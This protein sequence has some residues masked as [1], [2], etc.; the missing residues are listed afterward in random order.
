MSKK[1]P[2]T[3]TLHVDE[4]RRRLDPKQW[5]SD[6]VSVYLVGRC[7]LTPFVASSIEIR[8]SDIEE[9]IHP[10]HDQNGF[11]KWMKTHPQALKNIPKRKYNEIQDALSEL[12]DP[13]MQKFMLYDNDSSGDLDYEEFQHLSESVLNYTYNKQEFLSLIKKIDLDNNGKITFSE[14]KLFVENENHAE[15]PIAQSLKGSMFDQL[16]NIEEV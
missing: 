14:F 9:I 16:F 3:S 7:N 12:V 13:L 1:R 11:E 10:D 2:P 8:G 4:K 5:S 15:H 6:E